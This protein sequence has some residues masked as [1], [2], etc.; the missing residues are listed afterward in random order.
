MDKYKKELDSIHLDE[1]S[2]NSI[3]NH[4]Q[5]KKSFH[6]KRMITVLICFIIISSILFT[7]ININQST[8]QSTNLNFTYGYEG[9]TV[10][11]LDEITHEVG[12]IAH[13][14][15]YMSVYKNAYMRDG[16]GV[17]VNSL[18]EDEKE[19]ILLK[20]AD[21][22]NMKNYDLTKE[23]ESWTYTLKNDDYTIVLEQSTLLEIHFSKD[24]LN[25]HVINMKAENREDAY[26]IFKDL[27][28]QYKN[29]IQIDDPIYD[30]SCDYNIYK[31]K[32]WEFSLSQKEDDYSLNLM[33][34][35]LNQVK[36]IS[37]DNDNF[38]F[39]RMYISPII[40][41]KELKIITLNQAKDRL[42]SGQYY[43]SAPYVDINRYEYIEMTYLIDETKQY[44]LPYYKFYILEE[45][46]KGYKHYVTCYV[47]A[48]EETG[49]YL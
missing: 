6:Q 13:L 16:A 32:H 3:I 40:K 8:N 17:Q 18:T 42:K 23:E 46:E 37:D 22:L 43:T 5:R 26:R 33:N 21:L 27:Y 48:L 25:T 49:D 31:E 4:V 30:V 38:S 47:C 11:N 2:Y 12:N 24:Y 14:P 35:K 20:Y 44:F 7:K 36:F 28:Q 19:A 39:I 34:S 45:K 15:T 9:Y 41:D 29:I 1:Q 10:K